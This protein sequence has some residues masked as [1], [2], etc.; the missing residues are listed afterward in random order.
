[1][2]RTDLH[3]RL[4]QLLNAT[5]YVTIATV[6]SDGQ[7]WNTPVVGVF[8]DDLNLYWVSWK[9]SQ[10]SRNITRDSRIF[11]VVY[12]TA[13][14]EG[15]GLGLYVQMI[16]RP[17][18]GKPEIERASKVYNL[19]FFTLHDGSMPTFKGTCPSRIYMASPCKVWMNSG[20]YDDGHYIDIR[21][22]GRA[23]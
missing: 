21:V 14:P 1:M 12:D 8:D 3:K 6:G 4:Q 10:H 18:T 22:S 23:R 2:K 5:T 11:V 19:S 20:A 17:L 16:A 9:Q 15:E 13:A 7:P